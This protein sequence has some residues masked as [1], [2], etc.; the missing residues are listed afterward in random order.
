MDKQLGNNDFKQVKVENLSL[1]T[2]AKRRCRTSTKEAKI[3]E[4]FYK[5]NP[6]PNKEQ[7]E[8]IANV[9]QMGER[10]VHFW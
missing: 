2:Q 1:S 6:S 9:V 8:Q 5:K 10:N 7:K 4:D 3:L